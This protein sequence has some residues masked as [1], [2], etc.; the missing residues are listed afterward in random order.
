MSEPKKR[1]PGQLVRVMCNGA[2][3]AEME[4]R[5]GLLYRAHVCNPEDGA[6]YVMTVEPT[7]HFAPVPT[8]RVTA[9]ML[10]WSLPAAP[11]EPDADPPT[12]VEAPPP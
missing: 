9:N 6:E 11:P 3:V 1:V 5:D 10:D 7:V 4:I 12:V 2:V 8:G